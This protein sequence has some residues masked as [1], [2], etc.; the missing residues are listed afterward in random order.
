V[1]GQRV[2]DLSRGEA[3]VAIRGG[4]AGSEALVG[5]KI[6]EVPWGIY[7]SRAFIERH[8][9][10]MSAAELSRYAVIELVDE[11]ENLPAARWA[12]A[13]ASESMVSARCGNIPSVQLAV[14]SGAGIAPLPTVHASEDKNLVRVLGPIPELDYPIYLFVHKDLRKVR[15]VKAF[16]EFCV[17]EL[18]PVLMTG[19]LQ[20]PG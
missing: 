13:H 1:M 8:G 4:G 19:A 5:R 18:K 14:L 16:F 12:R 6:A 11:I 20:R 10:P 3:D 15:R 17:R 9:R 7:A 2:A